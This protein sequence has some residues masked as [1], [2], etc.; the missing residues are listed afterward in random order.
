MFGPIPP[1][2]LTRGH[3]MKIAGDSS[4]SVEELAR[5]VGKKVGFGSVKSAAKMNVSVMI[6]LDQVGKVSRVVEEGLAVGDLFV[7]VFPAGSAVHQ[8]PRFKRPSV[9]H[10]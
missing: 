2:L 4:C 6:F 9:H 1:P 3:G 5:A 8:S 7:Q 10:R